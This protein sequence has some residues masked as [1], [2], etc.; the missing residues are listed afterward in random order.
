MDISPLLGEYTLWRE[1]AKL[2][3][4]RVPLTGYQF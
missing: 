2:A 4:L 3:E 1:Q